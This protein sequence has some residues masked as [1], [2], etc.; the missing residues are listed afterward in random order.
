VPVVITPH[1]YYWLCPQV[2]LLHRERQV[3]EDYEGGRRCVGCLTEPNYS[4]ELRSRRWRHTGRRIFGDG[5]AWQFGLALGQ[6]KRHLRTLNNGR[7]VPVV[8]APPMTNGMLSPP[9]VIASPADQNERLLRARDHLVVLN[10]Y[11]ERRRAAVAAMN[12][13][14]AV[15]APS[16]FL[17]SVHAAMGVKQEK[18]R[19][20]PLGQPHFDAIH[21]AARRSPFYEQRPWCA[22]TA[23]RPL[24]I[25]YFGSSRY[26]KG[27][28]TM[29]R[30]IRDLP[31]D[32]LERSHFVM[33]AAGD[34]EP[35]KHLLRGRPVSWLG[36]YEIDGLPAT[37]AEF[38]VGVLPT[39]GLENSPFVLLE[40]L[41]GGKFVIA[42]RLGGPTDWII[43]G[44]N[45]LMFA[46]GDVGQLAVAISRVVRG[47]VP[48]PSPREVHEA[49]TLTSYEAHVGAVMSAYEQVSAAPAA[50]RK[51]P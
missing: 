22:K 15:L 14:D 47:E 39:V 8:D 48:L 28:E 9:R 36:G 35:F 41:H 42:S 31:A 16:R 27:L 12:L 21:D 7:E 50:Q 33:R 24:R 49:S 51:G 46:A 5:T 18:L 30:A 40:H 4:E 29:A 17:M 43:E 44:K 10:E 2:D 6:L 25:A 1:N 38:D 20:V 13:A 32:V 45:G 26:N 23:T 37:L 3:C 34:I 11:G 19:H